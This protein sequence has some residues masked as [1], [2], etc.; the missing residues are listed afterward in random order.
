MDSGIF[1][2]VAGP[3]G[4]GKTSL[5]K[6]LVAE[7]KNL[8][9]AVSVTTRA[10]RADEVDGIAYHFWDEQR[11]EDAAA[12]GEFLEHAVVHGQ[13]YGTLAQFVLDQMNAGIDVVKDIDV[14]GVEQ[15]GKHPLFG[16][17]YVSIFIMP[18]SRDTLV[19]RMKERGSETDET[20]AV[21]LRTADDELAMARE[22]EYIVTNDEFEHAMADLKA[23]R[24]A[25]HCLSSRQS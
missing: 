22:F 15:I 8:V 20:L 11:F 10:P 5:L 19:E 25:E 23:I 1:F 2:L 12:N 17:R 3:A 6:R 16:G 7:E 24:R 21:R 4:V 18:P 14:Q 9:K 13:R